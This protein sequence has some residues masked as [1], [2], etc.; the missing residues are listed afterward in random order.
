MLLVVAGVDA[1]GVSV[2]EVLVRDRAMRHRDGVLVPDAVPTD[3]DVARIGLR[4]GTACADPFDPVLPDLAAAAVLTIPLVEGLGAGAVLGRAVRVAV[5]PLV[6]PAHDESIVG[7]GRA[8]PDGAV[9]V[10]IHA[11][12]EIVELVRHLV[13]AVLVEARGRV[14]AQ[15]ERQRGREG[16][17]SAGADHEREDEGEGRQE[18]LQHAVFLNERAVAE[19][20]CPYWAQH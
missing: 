2:P 10:P 3:R 9:E 11:I 8:T 16:P 5:L 17:F 14:L 7:V 20:S 12:S 19:T 1:L 18:T 4:G 6:V 13:V 15:F